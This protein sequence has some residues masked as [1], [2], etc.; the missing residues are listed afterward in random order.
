[1]FVPLPP[2]STFWS[3][4]QLRHHLL[5]TNPI[6]R[7]PT[8]TF[9][10][11]TEATCS[12]TFCPKCPVP[13]VTSR[14]IPRLIS[15][16]LNFLIISENTGPSSD[17]KYA[18]LAK[19]AEA[20]AT[21]REIISLGPVDRLLDVGKRRSPRPFLG[22]YRLPGVSIGYRCCYVLLLFGSSIISPMNFL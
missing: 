7:M 2:L 14:G 18:P 20:Q 1:M 3:H 8:H 9:S 5:K 4:T 22:F 21:L 12:I 10:T 16:N 13:Y 11:N 17:P 19:T 15:Q 6:R